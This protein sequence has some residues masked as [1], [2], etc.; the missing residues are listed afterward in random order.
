M[1]IVFNLQFLYLPLPVYMSCA[2]V[3]VG[4]GSDIY[5]CFRTYAHAVVYYSVQRQKPIPSFRP[6]T[7]AGH[8]PYMCI[9]PENFQKSAGHIHIKMGPDIYTG[10][11]WVQKKDSGDCTTEA[12]YH[13]SNNLS[14]I[15]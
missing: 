4:R 14:K 8:L 15:K 1:G 12:N 3:R 13:Y 6:R 10:G 7:L 5:T 11:G 9:C 2:Y